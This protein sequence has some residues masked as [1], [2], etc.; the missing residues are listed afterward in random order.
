MTYSELIARVE[1]KIAQVG[2]NQNT[3]ACGCAYCTV[4]P[5]LVAAL[6]KS[7]VT[8]DVDRMFAND[9][10][11][12]IESERDALRAENAKLWCV[13]IH[14]K[15]LVRIVSEKIPSVERGINL[16]NQLEYTRE[17]LDALPERKP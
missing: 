13:A 6:R 7:E 16:G 8:G 11:L 4:V 5:E 15:A 2:V 10:I 14:A 17:F 1:Q 12:A 9:A 3:D